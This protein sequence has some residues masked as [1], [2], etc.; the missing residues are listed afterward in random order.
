MGQEISALGT[1]TGNF[2]INS[3]VIPAIG[4]VGTFVLA[5][6]YNTLVDPN[7]NYTCMAIRTIGE[8]LAENKDPYAIAY[9]P[10][11]I[12]QT[13][14]QEDV[15][16]N[17]PIISLVSD[18]GNWV[19]VP[20]SYILEIPV[21]N[22]INYKSIGINI[23]LGLIQDQYD[24]TNLTNQLEQTV[25]AV[26]GITP[27]ISPVQ[28]SNSLQV[29]QSQADQIESARSALITNN[30][31]LYG[32]YMNTLNSLQIANQQI[33]A[34]EAYIMANKVLLGLTS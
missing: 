7:V 21:V 23:I 24:L 19:Y 2:G 18:G 31:S 17:L 27:T 32:L 14:Y 26:T 15:Q 8:I 22:G 10:A 34:L 3:Y 5:T 9:Q 6:P 16:E 28:L 30:D 4:S 12:S 1:N 13:I 11:N 29:T 20:A 25:I 33:Q